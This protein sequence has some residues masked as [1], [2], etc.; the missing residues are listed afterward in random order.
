MIFCIVVS[1]HLLGSYKLYQVFWIWEIFAYILIY[2]IWSVSNFYS[3][4]LWFHVLLLFYFIIFCDCCRELVVSIRFDEPGWQWS[5]SFL[6]DRIGDTQVKMRN[7]VS[8]V[9][10]MV[11]VE[12]QNADLG[13]SNENL[14][15]RTNSNS[16]TQL[17]LLSDDK[18]GF[19]PYRID[20]FS[21]EV[22][23]LFELLNLE[24]APAF[25]SSWKYYFSWFVS[26]LSGR[27]WE[28]SNDL[29]LSMH[30]Y[31]NHRN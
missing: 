21:M 28:M 4:K 26:D 1:L 19:M 20:N 14:F 29:S 3:Y 15:K 5:G 31:L 8:G 7:Y 18:T 12:V 10:N 25:S 11:R 23:N 2:Q 22:I 27:S 17:I 9:S 24:F 16:T 6:P 30:L 13:I